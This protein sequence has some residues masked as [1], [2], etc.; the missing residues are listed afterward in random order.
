MNAYNPWALVGTE[1]YQG[2]AF[3]WWWSND[4]APW[5]GPITPLV[6]GVVLLA[7]GYL[8]GFIRALVAP[9]R[10]TVILATT[11]LAFGFFIL[12]TRVHE[13]YL[14]PV[15]AL[16]PLLAVVRTRWMVALVL[17]ALGSLINLHEIGRAH[18]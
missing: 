17:V 11:W 7:L 10:W 2:L 14:F 1:G 9:D 6:V 5:L 16:L 12:P 13:R 4:T 15:F 18:V 8:W 3:Q